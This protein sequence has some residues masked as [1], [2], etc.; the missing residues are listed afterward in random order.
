MN[1][2]WYQKI[3]EEMENLGNEE[4]AWP[5]YNRFCPIVTQF[6]QCYGAYCY[7]FIFIDTFYLSSSLLSTARCLCRSSHPCRKK[8]GVEL[9]HSKQ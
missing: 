8:V 7:T 5:R 2:P 1:L 9:E 3:R 4:I 6:S